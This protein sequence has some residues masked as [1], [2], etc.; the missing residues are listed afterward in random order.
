ML[1]SLYMRNLRD[2]IPTAT[3]V[4]QAFDSMVD[5][6]FPRADDD[7]AAYLTLSGAWIA[8]GAWAADQVVNSLE[9]G[10]SN[11]L[12]IIASIGATC[13]MSTV[14]GIFWRQGWRAKGEI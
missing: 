13:L 9:K 4:I 1:N 8:G 11:E 6:K 10:G 2:R 7:A 12:E 14:G 3:D 5:R